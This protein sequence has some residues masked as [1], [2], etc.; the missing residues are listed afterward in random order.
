MNKTLL[1]VI[2]DFLLLNLLALTHWEKAE[3]T[4]SI[5]T[6]APAAQQGAESRDQDMVDVMKLSLE[7]ER[8]QRE[9]LAQQLQQTQST[10]Q[11][12]EQNLS[13]LQQ[14]RTQLSSSLAVTQQQAQQLSQRVE[15][16]SRDAAVS[17]DR[18]AQMQRELEQRQADAQ[19]Q[20]QQLADLAK[21]QADAQQRIESL[22]VQ[23]KVAE[24]EKQMLRDTASTLRTQV[25]AEHQE[26]VKAQETTTQ[27]AQGVGQIA[28]QSTQLTKEI[29]EN[30]PIN[31]NTLFSDF[32]ANRVQTT[33]T[34]NR[35]SFFGPVNR[36]KETRTIF[37]TDGKN[38]Y[39]LLHVDDT[40]FAIRE[41]GPD[42]EKVSATFTK[43]EY[44]STSPEVRFLAVDPRV[45]VLPVTSEQVTAIGAKVYQLAADP[46]KFPEVVLISNG[47]EG[48]GEVTFKLDPMEPH[49]VRVDNH[50]MKRLFGDFAPSRGDVVL[51][52]TGELL[53]IMANSD[54]CVILNDFIP[55]KILRA[56]DEVK[57]QHTGTMFAD[58]DARLKGLPLKLQ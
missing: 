28:E 58:L 16:A 17:R 25:E 39:A 13:Q 9:Q 15:E 34:A 12:R 46:F 29:R 47:G 31:A 21:Q 56:G 35:G 24:Q 7:D 41:V 8:K 48:Y 49:Y 14:E 27:L 53:G 54:Y 1:L 32:L 45:V 42:W 22:N 43:G 55:A 37:F 20:Q 44:Q 2:C 26:R 11:S 4:R 5:E 10:L 33:F 19:R 30:R 51:S 50:L 57:E 6:P 52:K 38:N 23:V 18:L 40:P 3:P 36:S